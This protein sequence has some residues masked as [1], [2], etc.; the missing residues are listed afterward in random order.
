MNILD[1]IDINEK[2]R[3]FLYIKIYDNFG[4]YDKDN[5]QLLKYLNNYNEPT[6]N[7]VNYFLL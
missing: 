7:S 3:D 6:I 4:G 5:L 1:N 2:A